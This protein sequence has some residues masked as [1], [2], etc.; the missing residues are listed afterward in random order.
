MGDK[1][2][3]DWKILV[4]GITVILFIGIIVRVYF[5]NSNFNN[6]IEQEGNWQDWPIITSNP[7][8]RNDYSG[9]NTEQ[10]KILN[11][12]ANY[13]VNITFI[14]NWT[15]EENATSGIGE[16]ENQPDSF[17]LGVVTPWEAEFNSGLVSNP[18]GEPGI[19]NLTIEVPEDGIGNSITIGEWIVTIHCGD[20]GDQVS[21][22]S[23]NWVIEDG[24]NDWV[25]IYYYEYH[26]R[27]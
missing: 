14:L 16:Y 18:I 5:Q 10:E 6:E 22:A 24:G 26:S 27:G 25:L 11:I 13:V 17:A 9:E 12:Q 23:V 19:I 8:Y 21:I 1:K 2:Y 7:K 15:D 4:L 20:C 3:F